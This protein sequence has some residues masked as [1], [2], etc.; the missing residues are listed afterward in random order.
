MALES[1]EVLI[2]SLSKDVEQLEQL[3][4]E[5]AVLFRENQHSLTQLIAELRE[6]KAIDDAIHADFRRIQEQIY[7]SGSVTG[8]VTKV[9]DNSAKIGNI[10]KLL[11]A[12]IASMTTGAISLILSKFG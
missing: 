12:T 5:N 11:W 10:W 8:M 3:V 1:P 2:M 4:K 6:H 9:H 7:G